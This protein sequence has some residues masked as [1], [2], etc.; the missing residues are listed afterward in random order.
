MNPARWH[1]LFLPWPT[2]HAYRIMI[3]CS[4]SSVSQHRD[5][6][7]NETPCT[8]LPWYILPTAIDCYWPWLTFHIWLKNV[9]SVGLTPFQ[10]QEASKLMKLYI[11]THPDTP[12][13][14][15]LTVTGLD[16]LFMLG[17]TMFCAF[18]S[19]HTST[20]TTR[21]TAIKCHWPWPI[22]H[23]WLNNILSERLAPFL[24]HRGLYANE[25]SYS[26]P[27][28]HALSTTINRCWHLPNFMQPRINP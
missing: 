6:Y 5:I 25:T 12:F 21:S 20:M 28:W 27:P 17:W 8:H 2:I 23:N 16:L 24:E 15:P 1:Q 18:S 19:V 13:P 4:C 10:Q 11:H 3:V 7:A 9:K 14:L 26:H 22:F